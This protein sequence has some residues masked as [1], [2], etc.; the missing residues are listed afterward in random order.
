M[1]D[2][3]AYRTLYID[4]ETAPNTAH[5]WS[6]WKQ[7]ISLSQ[8]MES[9]RVISFAWK[10]RGEPETH[11]LSEFHV[12]HAAMIDAA[13]GLL[14][15]AD[16]VGHYNGKRFDMPTLNREF[17][18]AKLGP[19]APYQQL[20]FLETVKRRFRFPSNK[21]DYVAQQLGLAGKVKHEGH[22]LWVRCMAGDPEA[23]E[24]MKLYNMQDVVLL[25]QLHDR[26]MPW[27]VGAPNQRL[28][29]DG[30][31]VCPHCGSED[32]RREGYA[33]TSTGR[34]QRFQCR[35]CG[36]WSRATRR[37]DGTDTRPVSAT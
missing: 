20:D 3:G 28:V 35:G 13:H 26:L 33:L 24:L 16:V 30:D 32:L 18:V 8:L 15:Q 6:L 5:V 21:L 1:T 17:V 36:A 2:P 31:D 9:G 11:F 12:D 4:I 22:T 29:V 14:S 7:T 34:Y 25:E 23:W 37:F 27:L 19:P 10:W